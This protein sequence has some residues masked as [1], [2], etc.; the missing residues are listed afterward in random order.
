M[1][2][3][4]VEETRKAETLFGERENLGEK[5]GISADVFPFLYTNPVYE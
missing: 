2:G 4:K 3:S 5:S 1:L